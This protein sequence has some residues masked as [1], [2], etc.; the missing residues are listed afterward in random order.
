SG[1]AA[2]VD[3]SDGG[4]RSGALEYSL[5]GVTAAVSAALIA[6]GGV[7]LSRAVNLRAFC[8][9][10]GQSTE[11]DALIGNPPVNYFVSGGLSLGF[12]ALIAVASGM[13]FRRAVRTQRAYRAW[14]SEQVAL[15][16]WGG[17]RSGGLSLTLRF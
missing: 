13:L 2:T 8:A 15:R 5:G 14:H 3:L 4:T 12:S 9:E 16:P 7:Q 10:N 6:F 17:A 11:C 1:D